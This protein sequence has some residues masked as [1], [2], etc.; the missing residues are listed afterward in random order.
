MAIFGP[1][2]SGQLSKADAD[3]KRELAK[4]LMGSSFR[5]VNPLGA[6]AMGLEGSVS[7]LYDQDASGAEKAGNAQVAELLAGKD[8]TGAMGNEWASP[9]QAA[10]AA[11]LQGRDW[12]V[13]DRNAQWAREDARAAQARA[14]AA[15]AAS[16]P[17][18]KMF[19]AGGDQYRY[20]AN[21]PNSRPE[22]F[23]DGPDAA[24]D[25][26]ASVDEYNWYA[27]QEKAAG[28]QPLGL[29]DFEQAKKGNGMSVALP[30]GTIIQ[31]GGK[32]LTEGQSKDT[33]YATRAAG[34]LPKLDQ[35]GSELMN[36]GQKVMGAD[37][38]GIIRGQQSPEF[39]QADQAG[40]EFLQAILRKDTG[41]A[42]TA[43]E[44]AEYGK[45]YI[46]QPGD[47][48]Q[49]LEQKRQSRARAVEAIKA[50][51]PANAILASE[52]ALDKTSSSPGGGNWTD[53]GNGVR[54]RE[55]N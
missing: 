48:P 25:L 1:Q 45:V 50:G 24:P 54:I 15:A 33:V 46:P 4:Q 55:I 11:T 7:G 44:T 27:E 17:E 20:N 22:L 5:A 31:Q 38:T 43:D 29:I 34:A 40:L 8:Y 32:A 9:Q 19:E 3:R 14:E 18:F 42:I 41:A 39:Q 47:T 28:R 13:G 53:V 10:L 30:D 6:L 37:P 21:D 52:M 51:M 12:Q 16:R 2:S 49:L 23:F 26:P 35:Y 36:F